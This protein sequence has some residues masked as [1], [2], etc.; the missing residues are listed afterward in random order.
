[1]VRRPRCITEAQMRQREE[2]DRKAWRQAFG[3]WA[4]Y[5]E[6]GEI[7]AARRER[8]RQRMQ[9]L[10]EQMRERRMP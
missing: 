10:H 5:Q 7:I 6:I 2:D 1:M 8:S 3:M 4:D 9:R